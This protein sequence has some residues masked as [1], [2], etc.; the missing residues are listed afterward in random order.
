MRDDSERNAPGPT[1]GREVVLPAPRPRPDAAG[2]DADRN[3]ARPDLAELR[4][5]IA[6]LVEAVHR[7]PET[8]LELDEAWWRIDELAREVARRHPSA[9]RVRSRWLRLAPLLRELGPELPIAHTGKLVED[10]F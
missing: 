7:M 5:R 9:P 10:A 3:G 8:G 4:A 6:E 2:A 1:D